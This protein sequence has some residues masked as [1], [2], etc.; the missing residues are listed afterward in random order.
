M[1][2]P[3][4]LTLMKDQQ[5]VGFSFVLPYGDAN[6]HISCMCI[7]PEFR[8]MG[9]GELMLH[10]IMQNAPKQGYQTIT[11]GTDTSMAAYKL[12]E[13]NGFEVMDGNLIWH[14]LLK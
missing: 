6:C 2:E 9:L 1:A 12:Y 10:T 7:A 5:L 3:T 13:K 8:R 4:S 11:L 14:R